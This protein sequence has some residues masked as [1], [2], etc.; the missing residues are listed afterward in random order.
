M[1]TLSTIKPTILPTIMPTST[2]SNI[3][4]V[5]VAGPVPVSASHVYIRPLFA[6]A[7]AIILDRQLMKQTN[8]KSNLAFGAAVG[9]SIMASSTVASNLPVLNFGSLTNG[10]PI[11]QRLTEVVL[12]SSGAYV[13]NKYAL[14]NIASTHSSPY[15]TY[16]SV[17]TEFMQRVGVVII[18]DTLASVIN[19]YMNGT[20]INGF[21]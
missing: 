7:I 5:V 4:T 8:Y 21:S 15:D 2:V 14:K 11:T 13:L 19:E 17:N 18:A 20:V 6:S 9:L 12:G 16:P 3:S 10:L 1:S